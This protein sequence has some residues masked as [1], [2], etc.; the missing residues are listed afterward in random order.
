MF[1][2]RID[3][4]KS[5]QN[6]GVR[7]WIIKSYVILEKEKMGQKRDFT[8]RLKRGPGRSSKKQ[9]PPQMPVQFRKDEDEAPKNLSSRAKKRMKNR[10]KKKASLEAGKA[11]KPI[12]NVVDLGSGGEKSDSDLSAFSSDDEDLFPD[13]DEV[14]APLG[15][16]DS[17]AVESD[18]EDV[19]GEEEVEDSDET[20][21]AQGPAKKKSIQ[22]GYSDDNKSWLTPSKKSSLPMD[23][24]ES[25]DEDES[26]DDEDDDMKDDF[27]DKEESSNSEDSDE[28]TDGDN[29]EDGD[30]DEKLLPIEKAT[31]R[32]RKKQKEDDKLAEEELQTNIA[33]T[34]TF[35]LPSGQ[36]IEKEL[37]QAADLTLVQQ[38]IKDVKGVLGDFTNRRQDGRSRKEYLRQL[39]KDLC[40][41]YS[42]NDYL[43]GE[44][45]ELFPNEIVDFLESNEVQRPVTIRTNTLK[46]RRRD[47]AQA[48]INRGVNL[49][50][51]GK[52]SKVGLVVYDAQVPLGATP[53]YLAGHYLL[54]GGSSFLPV[55]A[56]A[57]QENEKLLDMSAA[58]GGK[59]TYAAALMRNTGLIFA[60]DANE[61]RAKAIV[62]N[63]HRMGITNTVVTTYDGRKF[64]KVM[65]NFDRVLLDAPCSGTGVISK[66]QAVKINKDEKDIARC[67]HLQKELLLAAIDCCDAKSKTGGYIIY[68]TCSVM[69]QENEDVIEYALKKRNVKLVST[70]L[71]FGREGFTKMQGKRFHQNMK[72]TRRFYPHAHNMDGF[73]VA[74][75]KK[76]SNKIPGQES[77]GAEEE[78]IDTEDKKES[79]DET[80]SSPISSTTDKAQQ[81]GQK[82]KNNQRDNSKPRSNP[83]KRKIIESETADK[84][85]N[86]EDVSKSESV[87]KQ[88]MKKSQSSLSPSGKSKVKKGSTPRKNKGKIF[89]RKK[90]Y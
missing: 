45:M 75:L 38:R 3:G 59:T 47:L 67:A 56:L 30:D 86:S 68:S 8:E 43:M 23:D 35:I 27:S 32:L 69:Y 51:I 25:E 26:T 63:I 53:E 87:K 70:E 66:D 65:R 6:A 7:I 57:P 55:M 89:K 44:L 9:K 83:K 80:T 84:E 21:E 33:E 46:T 82:N 79:D 24:D 13:H 39:R 15:E 1:K 58:P 71:D 11:K 22:K 4:G 64:P 16:S 40:T 10:L 37:V 36:E 61:D 41:Y 54:Q 28:S 81:K 18:E 19:S 77:A 42:Y 62:G 2:I 74:K 90:K 88:K 48:L 72:L 76:F 29:D 5:G 49:D 14:E 17:D 50:P 78:S 12:K 20:E 73:F 34:E 31:K 52:W 60:N 85:E